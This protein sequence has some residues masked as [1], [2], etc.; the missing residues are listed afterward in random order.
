MRRD[1]VPG[2]HRRPASAQLYEPRITGD[3]ANVVVAVI[4]PFHGDRV[5]AQ[6]FSRTC[7]RAGNG[8]RLQKASLFAIS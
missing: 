3:T 5:F 4:R 8:W 7:V 6:G 2:R 1:S